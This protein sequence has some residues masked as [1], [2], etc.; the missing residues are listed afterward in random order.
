M[1]TDTQTDKQGTKREDEELPV[2][3][4]RIQGAIWLL[5]LAILAWQQ[6][7]WPGILVLLAISGLTQAA[8]RFYLSRQEEARQQ[9]AQAQ[10]LAERQAAWLPQTC[11]N[12]GGPISVATVRW[13]GS[14][15]ADCPFCGT[16]LKEPATPRSG[17]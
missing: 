15:T 7:W 10:Q 17:A 8:I 3:W 6:W 11:P 9:A 16:H 1:D 13:T 2:P 14:N 12:C 5:G 4:Q